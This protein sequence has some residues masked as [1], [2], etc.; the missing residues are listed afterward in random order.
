M[1][2]EAAQGYQKSSVVVRMIAL[3]AASVALMAPVTLAP[4]ASAKSSHYCGSFIVTGVGEAGDTRCLGEEKIA[5]AASLPT[6]GDTGIRQVTMGLRGV[7]KIQLVRTSAVYYK[8]QNA[9]RYQWNFA[10]YTKGFVGYRY[11]KR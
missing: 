9:W 10:D 2:G 3:L 5:L 1:N 6:C 11:C 7:Y 8:Q 4:A